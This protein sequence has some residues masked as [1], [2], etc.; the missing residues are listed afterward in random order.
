MTISAL[1]LSNDDICKCDEIFTQYNKYI[2]SYRHERIL[3]SNNTLARAITI[4][5]GLFMNYKI[6]AETAIE[7]PD[8]LITTNQ[9][10]KP[11]LC[12]Y[13]DYYFSISHSEKL[14]VYTS[15][16]NPI[17]I[18][19][20]YIRTYNRKLARRFFHNEE[21]TYLESISSHIQNTEF[22]RIW[23]MKEA[24]VKQNGSGLAM[25]L[26]SFSVLSKPDTYNFKNIFYDNYIIS[27]Y[28]TKRGISPHITNYSTSLILESLRNI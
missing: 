20:E 27:L 26:D 18:D 24:Y 10:G 19:T 4:Y 9:F 5:A 21:Y 7:Y 28:T 6:H 15:D 23:T 17:G 25:P 22:T 1:L 14:I 12:N 3:S 2:P 13:N 8:I 16:N 11:V